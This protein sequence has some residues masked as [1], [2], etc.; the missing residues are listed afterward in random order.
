[1]GTNPDGADGAETNP[2]AHHHD[3]ADHHE[4]AGWPFTDAAGAFGGRGRR[5][6]PDGD[7]SG[8]RNSRRGP[9]G[10]PGG[11]M[12]FGGPRYGGPRRSRGDVR[13]A[14]LALLTEEPMHGYQM[15]QEITER[16]GGR[17][18]PSPG[19]VYPTLQALE[20]EGLV[21]A[22]KTEGKRVYE[23][24]DAGRQQVEALGE[25]AQA[26]WDLS[27]DQAVGARELADQMRQF[28]A[29]FA[30]VMQTGSA[31]QM[32]RAKTILS[33]GRRALYQILAEDE[34]ADPAETA[35]SA[36]GDQA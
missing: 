28:A 36:P 25:R 19:S 33:D 26:P 24:T 17:W 32:A 8:R 5:R 23:L 27:G 21:N 29:A 31:P 22:H 3:H 7:R 13:L 20:D 1:M 34:S 14:I 11:A 16:S 4:A 30:Q 15:I 10:G 12:W 35:P 9:R 2:R 18:Q 6:W